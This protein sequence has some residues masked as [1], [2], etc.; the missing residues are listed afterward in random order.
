MQTGFDLFLFVVVT[1]IPMG[2]LIDYIA[3]KCRLPMHDGS[4]PSPWAL[5]GLVWPISLFPFLIYC[6]WYKH[7]RNKVE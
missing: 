5:L 1:W 6:L 7:S 3:D 2:I 4:N